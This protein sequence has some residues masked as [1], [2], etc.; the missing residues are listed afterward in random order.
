MNLRRLL[1]TSC[2]ATA[3]PVQ[4]QQAVG[5]ESFASSDADNTSVIKTGV[6]FD[7]AHRD[8]EHYQ[9]IKFEKAR[10]APFGGRAVD[11]QRAYYRFADTGERWKWR[12]SLGTDGDTWLGSASLYTDEAR[13]Q[14]YFL[15]REIVETPLGLQ[16][17]IYATFGGA[18]LDVP[19][20]E[21]NIVTGLMGVQDFSGDNT[22][23]HLRGRYIRV[24]SDDWGLS[25]QLRTRYFRS[26]E[27]REFDYYSPRW[28]AEAIPMLQLRRFRGGWVYQG[29]AGW[30]RQRDSDSDWRNARLLEASVTSPKTRGWFFKAN[31]SYSNT[32][33]NTGYSYD[34][35]QLMLEAFVTF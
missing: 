17:G 30:G 19:L 10:F 32:P 35:T 6:Y 3:L 31:A 1:L 21:R 23:L 7:F 2:L 5:V 26:S 25:A 11:D 15:E 16:R 13:R 9:G 28:Y 20:N 22:R 4:A 18:A 8:L 29:A 12:G 34:Y 33:I 27:P 14:E 24:L